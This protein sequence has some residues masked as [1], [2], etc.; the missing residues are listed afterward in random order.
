MELKTYDAQTGRVRGHDGS[1]A[2][3]GFSRSRIDIPARKNIVLVGMLLAAL[4]VIVSLTISYQLIFLSYSLLTIYIFMSYLVMWLDGA[5]KEK[6]PPLPK[7]WPDVTI[8]IPSVNS[9]H[10]IFDAIAACKRMNYPKQVEIIVVDDGSTDGSY[11]KMKQISG[12]TLLHKEK[13][14]G[15]AAAIN[16]GVRRAKGEIIGTMDSDTY[17]ESHCLMRA[18]PHFYTEGKVGSVVLFVCAHKPTNLLQR[19]QEIEYWISFG[20]FF[21]TVA[22]IDGLYVT[23][24]PMAFYH[25]DMFAQLGG[26][27]EK[28]LTEDMEI[29]LRMQR[30]GWKIRACHDA[31]A[32]TDVPVTLGALFRQRLRWFRGGIMNMLKYID[33]F[34]NPQYGNFG[35]FVLPTTLGSGF[36]AA[37]FVLWTISN[38]VR[39]A[40]SWGIPWVENPSVI[41]GATFG[42]LHLDPFLIDSVMIFG[43]IGLV[44]WGYFL[45]KSFHLSRQKME[46][47]H[48]LPLALL[49]WFYPLF[50]GFTFLVSYASEFSGQKYKW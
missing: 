4:A 11:E 45:Y 30:H 41:S 8:V 29:A 27:D 28:N 48:L 34:L 39:A 38:Y 24:G 31:I 35:L 10:T 12:I 1:V 33:M 19:L 23:P 7:E 22:S 40:F 44:I 46:V 21:K 42:L 47:R 2:P 37:L 25:K 26:F 5:W 15:K 49:L 20:F 18:I 32:F 13:N 43:L 9:G 14:E 6:H 16:M 3:P 17:P 50:I 36:F